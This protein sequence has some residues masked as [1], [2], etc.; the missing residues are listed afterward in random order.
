MCIFHSEKKILPKFHFIILMH[1]CCHGNQLPVLHLELSAVQGRV[2]YMTLASW[3]ACWFVVDCLLNVTNNCV[4]DLA[5]TL[6]I[7]G[8]RVAANEVPS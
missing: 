2:F 1:L 3:F 7:S 5:I 4:T 6:L 8:S